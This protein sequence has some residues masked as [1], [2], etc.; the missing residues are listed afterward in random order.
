MQPTSSRPKP[1]SVHAP[2]ICAMAIAI[3][4]MLIGFVAGF[5]GLW[6]ISLTVFLASAIIAVEHAGIFKS[7]AGSGPRAVVAASSMIYISLDSADTVSS[8]RANAVLKDAPWLAGHGYNIVFQSE[9]QITFV[10]NERHPLTILGAVLLFPI[11]LLLLLTGK[12]QRQLVMLFSQTEVRY[13]RTIISGNATKPVAAYFTALQQQSTRATAK[14]IDTEEV[15]A[16]EVNRS[17]PLRRSSAADQPMRG[18]RH[19]VQTGRTHL[20]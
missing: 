17:R 18:P 14:Q 4:C 5:T 8:L 11:G 13:A 20:R 3:P 10:R 19:S 6:L 2:S 7:H 9:D 12:R 15:R 1:K 16:V